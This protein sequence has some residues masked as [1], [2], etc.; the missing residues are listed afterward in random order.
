MGQTPGQAMMPE[1]YAVTWWCMVP[2][3]VR[4]GSPSLSVNWGQVEDSVEQACSQVV[5]MKRLLR[6]TL[7]M[8]SRDILHPIWVSLKEKESLPK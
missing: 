8:V 1:V 2:V 7:A 5:A 6:E 3:P 4:T